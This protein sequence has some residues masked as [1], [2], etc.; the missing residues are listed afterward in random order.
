M[1]QNKQVMEGPSGSNESM[2]ATVSNLLLTCRNPLGSL[3]LL[4]LSTQD[5]LKS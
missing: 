1:P 3:T 5:E 2:K 4:C